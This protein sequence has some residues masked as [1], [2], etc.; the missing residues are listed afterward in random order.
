MSQCSV[1]QFLQPGLTKLQG[2][3]NTSISIFGTS[4]QEYQGS[5]TGTCQRNLP[6]NC[7]HEFKKTRFGYPRG[8]HLYG[9]NSPHTP[10]HDS[11]GSHAS[12][13]NAPLT[14]TIAVSTEKC[15]RGSQGKPPP[16]IRYIPLN[17]IYSG[18]KRDPQ[19]GVL[20]Q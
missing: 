16:Q 4:Q 6:E 18:K 5:S 12:W 3:F 19:V 14:Q 15:I 13:S 20:Y 1:Y 9:E 17:L 11:L 10:A 7:A 2:I 8:R